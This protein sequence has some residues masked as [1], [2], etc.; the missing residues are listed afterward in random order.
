MQ[1]NAQNVP[2]EVMKGHFGDKQSTKMSWGGARGTKQDGIQ[3]RLSLFAC[4]MREKA[5]F[6]RGRGLVI[7]ETSLFMRRTE[8]L[9]RENGMF[10]SQWHLL[11]CG[12]V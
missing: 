10:I 1:Y 2:S 12:F 9:M 11:P 6:M 3:G 5:L 7:R 4:P 8:P